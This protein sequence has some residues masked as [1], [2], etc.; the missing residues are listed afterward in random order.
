V[1]LKQQLI[2]SFLPPT[3]EHLAIDYPGKTILDFLDW[4]AQER[5]TVPCLAKITLHCADHWCNR[6]IAC[7][8][9]NGTPGLLSQWD[10]EQVVTD[11]RGLGIVVVF[12]EMEDAWR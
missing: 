1:P 5:M 10:A 9:E 7:T 8:D 2:E 4:V 3:L 12:L 11:L 6:G